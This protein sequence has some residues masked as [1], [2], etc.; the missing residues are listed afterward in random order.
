M[1]EDE[2]VSSVT[3]FPLAMVVCDFI[4]RDPY[5]GKFTL[6]G[7]FSQI[8]GRT[9]P[10]KHPHLF[11]Y[12]ALTGGRGE[13]PLRM[14]LW[15][16]DEEDQPLSVIE[17]KINCTQDPRATHE[18]AF[19]FNGLVFPKPGEYRLSLFANDEFMV[20]RRILVLKQP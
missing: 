10:L 5:T 11:V 9:F 12:S 13:I 14:E 20:E 17:D 3:P 19:G 4:Y 15:H 8:T 16:A 1:S 18:I 6:T 2:N 7:T